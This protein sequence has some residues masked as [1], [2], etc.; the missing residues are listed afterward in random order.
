MKKRKN[1]MYHFYKVMVLGKSGIRCYDYIKTKKNLNLA[2]TKEIIHA[3]INRPDLIYQDSLFLGY[4]KQVNY[5]KIWVEKIS[6]IKY[7][8]YCFLTLF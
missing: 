4:L 8:K 2:T 1:K 3:V 6:F 5:S 7:Y